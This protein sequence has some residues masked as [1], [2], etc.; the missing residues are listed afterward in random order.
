[1]PFCIIIIYIP[2]SII[3]EF[4]SF[5]FLLIFIIINNISNFI[6]KCLNLFTT[7]VFI[8]IN[9]V[10]VTY[11]RMIMFLRIKSTLPER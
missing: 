2:V 5:V 7:I 4:L 9:T 3:L 6:T 10:I 8:I 11:I 1:M